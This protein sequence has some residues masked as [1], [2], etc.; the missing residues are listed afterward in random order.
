LGEACGYSVRFEF[1]LPRAY[2]SILFCTIGFLLR[3]LENGLRGV[4]GDVNSD[5]ILVILRDMVHTYPDLRVVLMSATIDTTL[6]SEYFNQMS[7][8]WPCISS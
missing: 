7:G 6:F 2:G 3:R 4:V 1:A 8:A 5:F